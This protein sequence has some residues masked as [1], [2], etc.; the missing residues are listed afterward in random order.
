MIAAK[1]LMVNNEKIITF[2][3]HYLEWLGESAA[4]L[5]YQFVENYMMTYY[6]IMSGKS[7]KLLYFKQ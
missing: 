1:H 7:N 4:Y 3:L 5:E 6:T 2:N